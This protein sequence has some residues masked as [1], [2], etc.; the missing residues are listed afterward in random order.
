MPRPIRVL[1]DG[2]C[3]HI[4]QR[5]HNKDNLFISLE[6]FLKFKNILNDYKEKFQFEIYHYCIMTN[7]F[8]IILRVA[9]GIELPR[10]LQGIAQTYSNWYK[11][12]YKHVGYLYQSRYKSYIID[13]DAYLL[14]CGRYI[15][16]NPVRTK[17]VSDPGDYKWSSYNFYTKDIKDDILTPNPAYLELSSDSA[18]RQ[19]SYKEYVNQA[20]PYEQILDKAIMR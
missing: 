12:R 6:D 18:K 14:D 15:E 13:N 9:I 5:G 8:H 17:I 3:Y 4:I 19:K 7:H 2:A 20:R 11:S 16:R 10:I 1:Y